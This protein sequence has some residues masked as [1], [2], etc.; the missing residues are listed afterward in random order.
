MSEV[1]EEL[2]PKELG[3]QVYVESSRAI[4]E[5]GPKVALMIGVAVLVWLFG[6]LVFIPLSEGLMLRQYPVTQIISLI[7]LS[8]LAM[9][10]LSAVV[11]TRRLT[12]AAAGFLAYSI[13]ARRGEV[14]Q[15]ELDHYRTALTGISMVLIIALAFLLFSA[16]LT[17]IHPALTGIALIVAVIWAMVTLWRSGSALAAEIKTA[18][19]E[20]AKRVEKRILE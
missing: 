8:T 16:N 11:Q 7:I 6:N 2:T 4:A 3:K 12:N 5:G 1:R 17:T 15:E 20:L 9:L 19:D 10:V 13:G 18:A 14:T